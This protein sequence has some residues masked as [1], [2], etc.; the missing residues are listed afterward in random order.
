MFPLQCFLAT[1]NSTY[2][3]TQDLNSG[4]KQHTYSH[5]LIFIVLG[6][7]YLVTLIIL[8]NLKVL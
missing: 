7:I 6:Y 2:Q 4:S 8:K 1:L 3:A 5:I